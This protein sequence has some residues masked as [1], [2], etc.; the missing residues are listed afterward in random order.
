MYLPVS[1]PLALYQVVRY[2]V[3]RAVTFASFRAFT[4]PINRAE[5]KDSSLFFIHSSSSLEAWALHIDLLLIAAGLR[6]IQIHL[7]M[8]QLAL[9]FVALHRCMHACT[10]P[11]YR[12]PM[13]LLV[14]VRTSMTCNIMEDHW[15]KRATLQRTSAL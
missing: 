15:D 2:Q 11:T 14:A 6:A 9:C 10:D 3:S 1:E 12:V 5:L 7:Y 8:G 13:A 4:N